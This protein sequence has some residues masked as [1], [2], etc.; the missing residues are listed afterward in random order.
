MQA[1]QT[2]LEHPLTKMPVEKK[3]KMMEEKPLSRFIRDEMNRKEKLLEEILDQ[4]RLV[5]KRLD[6]YE[7][8]IE[9][10]NKEPANNKKEISDIREGISSNKDIIQKQGVE[11]QFIKKEI[12]EAKGSLKQFDSRFK[13]IE[14]TLSKKGTDIAKLEEDLQ[15][16]NT[17]ITALKALEDQFA[18]IQSDQIDI[19]DENEK[20]KRELMEFQTLLETEHQQQKRCAVCKKAA[21]RRFRE[22]SSD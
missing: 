22:H 13:Q 18:S 16:A 2:M 20:M 4:T 19:T 14:K 3:D 21:R 5:K 7:K 8:Q 9:R 17:E 10:E 12:S 6:M 1:M 15:K 11:T